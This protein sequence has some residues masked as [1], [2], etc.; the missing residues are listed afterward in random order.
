MNYPMAE[1]YYRKASEEYPRDSLIILKLAYCLLNQGK[2]SE[3]EG[4]LRKFI[5]KDPSNAYVWYLLGLALYY[6]GKV[7]EIAQAFQK[8]TF[9]NPYYYSSYAVARISVVLLRSIYSGN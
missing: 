4:Y 1:H 6:Q 9:L 3:A 7:G 2:W 8:A 5:E